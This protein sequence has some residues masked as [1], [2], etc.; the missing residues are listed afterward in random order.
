M[1]ALEL[2]SRRIPSIT[3]EHGS[4]V[5]ANYQ[6]PTLFGR[7]SIGKNLNNSTETVERHNPRPTQPT[8]NQQKIRFGIYLSV[9]FKKTL[10]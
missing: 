4:T 2:E 10:T 5:F 1:D 3:G 8:N 6:V 9:P 7:S